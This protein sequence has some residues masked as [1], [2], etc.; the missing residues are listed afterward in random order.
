[1]RGEGSK[2]REMFMQQHP[3]VANH[4]SLVYANY[5]NITDEHGRNFNCSA[6]KVGFGHTQLTYLSPNLQCCESEQRIP[7]ICGDAS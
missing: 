2:A 6:T 3:Q 5:S 4:I 7:M 1:M